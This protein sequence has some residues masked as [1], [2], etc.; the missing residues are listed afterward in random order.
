MVV[1]R[2]VARKL[3]KLA[4]R[5]E[6]SIQGEI[7]RNLRALGY[8]VSTFS[9]AQRAQQTAGIPDVLALHA[10]WGS[11]WIEVKRPSRRNHAGGGCTTEQLQWAIHARRCGENVM[12]AYGWA[13]VL[14]ELK[15]LGAPIT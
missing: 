9:Q 1:T 4:E 15:R 10:K 13:D 14:E 3:A 7:V 5:S 2:A 12:V 6:K 11:L 8:F